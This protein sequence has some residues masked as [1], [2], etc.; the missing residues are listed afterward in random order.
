MLKRWIELFFKEYL[1]YF[2]HLIKAV[3]NFISSSP[4][5]ILRK[6]KKYLELKVEAEFLW[7]YLVV[8]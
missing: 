3:C 5:K 8:I 7:S 6:M 2:I 1:Y 4:F